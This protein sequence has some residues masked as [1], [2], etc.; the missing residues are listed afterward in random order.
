MRKKS[1]RIFC[2]EGEVSREFT[3]AFMSSGSDRIECTCCGRVHFC[4]EHCKHSAG[5][6]E[7]I[8]HLDRQSKDDPEGWIDHTD[9]DFVSWF[10]FGGLQVVFG[11]PCRF[12]VLL[13]HSLWAWRHDICQYLVERSA[14]E[15]ASADLSLESARSI[16][17]AL[18]ET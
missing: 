11:C 13:E 8:S 15:K 18:R 16:E 4:L 10:E 5:D 1:Y 12:D 7:E 6:E 17:S 14:R 9:T 2:D 3:D